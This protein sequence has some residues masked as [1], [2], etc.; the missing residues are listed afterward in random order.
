MKTADFIS[1]PPAMSSPLRM[2]QLDMGN[3]RKF[4]P[5]SSTRA[6][7]LFLIFSLIRLQT[8]HTHHIT[9]YHITPHHIISHS[10]T[11]HH[12]TSHHITTQEHLDT[13]AHLFF[14]EKIPL[15]GLL[16]SDFANSRRAFSALHF[17]NTPEASR[18]ESP[19]RHC[20]HIWGGQ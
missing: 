9:S 20:P 19:L 4:S 1:V 3:V 16:Y 13:L 6:R 11:S 12:I 10:V 8:H 18:R 14:C 7:Q 2:S 17:I 5:I 15:V